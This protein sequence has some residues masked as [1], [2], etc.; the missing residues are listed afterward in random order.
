MTRATGGL[1][2][3]P[4]LKGRFPFRL[5][6]TSFIAPADVATNVEALA[7]LVDD[8]EVV[9]FES[10]EVSPLPDEGTLGLMRRVAEKQEVTFTIHLPLDITLASPDPSERERSLAKCA[11]VIERMREVSPFAY[12]AHVTGGDDAAARESLKTLG[13]VCGGPALLCVE[14]IA[15]P[16]SALAALAADAGVSL[17]LDVGHALAGGYPFEEWL[18]EHIARVRVVHVH[19]VAGAKD[20]RDLSFLPEGVLERIVRTLSES[21]SRTRVLTLE[22]FGEAALARSIAAMEDLAP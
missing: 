3:V 14:N 9:V 16:T 2:A 19:G 18:A 13:A 11:R 8:I 17:C 10:D 15:A 5:G 1:A 22:V 7:P 21:K 12:V 6:T 4:V 20:H